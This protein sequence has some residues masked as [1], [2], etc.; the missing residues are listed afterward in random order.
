[1]QNL[2]GFEV[3]LGLR[4]EIKNVKIFI[5]SLQKKKHFYN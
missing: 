1:M 2:N 3:Y 5:I 4:F